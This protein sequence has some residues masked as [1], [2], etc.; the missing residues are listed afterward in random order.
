MVGE[1][2][3]KKRFEEKKK[4]TCFLFWLIGLYRKHS[5]MRAKKGV[6]ISYIKRIKKNE[7]RKVG[8]E[9]RP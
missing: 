3:K 9:E 4:E 1:K 6:H 5:N 2:L 8:R 7:K